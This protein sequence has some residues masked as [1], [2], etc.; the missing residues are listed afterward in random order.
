MLKAHYCALFIF[1]L[2]VLDRIS[3]DHVVTIS[4]SFLFLSQD[5]MNALVLDL[6][7]PALRKNKNVE[8]ILNRCKYMDVGLWVN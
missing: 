5:S 4:C 8:T 2:C 1:Q 6:D 3:S 7:Y